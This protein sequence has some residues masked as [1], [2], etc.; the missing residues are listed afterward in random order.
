VNYYALLSVCAC[1]QRSDRYHLGK[2][3]FLG[4]FTFQGFSRGTH[5]VNS[6]A[7]WR[8]LVEAADIIEDE[9]GVQVT[10]EWVI[11]CSNA[12]GKSHDQLFPHEDNVTID[13]SVFI[14]GD[15]E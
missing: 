12:Y 14:Y 6:K 7:E 13:G 1:C 3:K 8:A 10:K 11:Q 15:W 2:T 9:D 4:A 5:P